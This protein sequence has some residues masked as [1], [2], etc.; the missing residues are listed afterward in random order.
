MLNILEYPS[1][2]SIRL[3][4]NIMLIWRMAFFRGVEFTLNFSQL[5]I[6]LAFFR[7][8]SVF[9]SKNEREK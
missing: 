5:G 6:L 9:V 4:E 2:N 3:C 8:E 1:Y 7:K